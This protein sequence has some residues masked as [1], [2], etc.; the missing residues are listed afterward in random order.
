MCRYLE[1]ILEQ[2]AI[3]HQY[4]GTGYCG[5]IVHGRGRFAGEVLASDYNNLKQSTQWVGSLQSPAACTENS[6]GEACGDKYK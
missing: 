5:V 6:T 2:A 4:E 3:S 1:L